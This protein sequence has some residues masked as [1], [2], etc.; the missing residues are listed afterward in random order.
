MLQFLKKYWQI[1]R[2]KVLKFWTKLDT[3]HPVAAIWDFLKKLD[4]DFC[5]L[6]IPNH[7]TIMIKKIIKV[8]H[9]IQGCIIFGQLG[10]GHFFGGKLAIVTLFS[11]LC[12]IILKCLN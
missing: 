12:P 2:Y 8:D 11:L 7:N 4:C 5:L 1:M 6:Q 10:Q 3:N 9:K